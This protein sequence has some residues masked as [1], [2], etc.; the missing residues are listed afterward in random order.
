MPAA[1]AAA[2]TSL[3][4]I[5][6][7]AFG[8]EAGA[9]RAW[10][11]LKDRYKTVIGDLTPDIQRAVLSEDRV[12]YRLRA[13]FFASR[14]EAENICQRLKELGQDCLASTR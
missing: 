6:L 13:G 9:E 10:R 12:L 5:Q 11:I 1:E 8:E 7:G 14:D 3:Y 4:I 2:T